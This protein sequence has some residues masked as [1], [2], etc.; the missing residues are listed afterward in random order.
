[1]TSED[2]KSYT[3]K[4]LSTFDLFFNWPFDQLFD[5][6]FIY[7]LFYHGMEVSSIKDYLIENIENLEYV[8]FF[9]V[10]GNIYYQKK[11]ELLALTT[12]SHA[13]LVAAA[14]YFFLLEKKASAS[15][16]PGYWSSVFRHLLCLKG[17]N[18]VLYVFKLGRFFE[19][20]PLPIIEGFLL[21]IKSLI[22]ITNKKQLFFILSKIKNYF[23]I[24]YHVDFYWYS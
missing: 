11:R 8:N 14:V 6:S 18:E 22:F 19:K 16:Y 17:H 13:N 23:F 15:D 12:V 5:R 2:L 7:D 20:R 3:V 1:M 9:V 4:T 10:E 24:F 21:E